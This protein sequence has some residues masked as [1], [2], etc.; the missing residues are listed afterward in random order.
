MTCE[1]CGHEH[2]ID[3]LCGSRPRWTRRG[4]LALFGAG[5]LGASFV[6]ALPPEA[7][8]FVPTPVN[9]QLSATIDEIIK[10]YY[11]Q[12][13]ADFLNGRNTLFELVD[14][15][16]VTTGRRGRLHLPLSYGRNED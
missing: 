15:D 10:R 5:V 7:I 1:W 12:P 11:Q 8:P 14:V 9:N 3:A 16:A 6:H 2:A 13:I 4:F